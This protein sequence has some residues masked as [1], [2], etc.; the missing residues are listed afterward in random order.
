MVAVYVPTT[1]VPSSGFLIVV[2]AKDVISTDFSVDDAMKIIISGGI[3][4]GSIMGDPV[5][6][7]P[8]LREQDHD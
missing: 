4:A 1:P 5:T 2:P 7:Q 6:R 3:L 8:P